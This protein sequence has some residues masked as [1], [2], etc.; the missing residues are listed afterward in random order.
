ML[1]NKIIPLLKKNT[2]KFYTLLKDVKHHYIYNQRYF[3]QL[4][5][6]NLNLIDHIL[7][8]KYEDWAKDKYFKD[9]KTVNDA[10]VIEINNSCNIN[11]VMCDTKSSTRKKKLMSLDLV[12][13][14]VLEIKKKI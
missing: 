2:P 12:E 14:S 1:Y 13:K 9:K 4:L 11:C 5:S 3:N 8:K 7:N 6:S 10:A